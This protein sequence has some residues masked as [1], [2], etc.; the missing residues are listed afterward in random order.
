M[1]TKKGM[2]DRKV[3]FKTKPFNGP[4]REM[5]RKELEKVIK[6][7]DSDKRSFEDVV[8]MDK[9]EEIAS[10]IMKVC[11][12]EYGHTYINPD[13]MK[14]AV[15]LGDSNPFG[16]EELEDWVKWEII[17]GYKDAELID[18]EVDAEW[19]PGHSE[20][21]WKKFDGKKFK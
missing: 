13:E 11:M 20:D 9:L 5:V 2:T 7:D 19:V 1:D 21:G 16:L 8:D 15:V 6:E 17:D 12:G 10:G 4:I 3:S 18:V 14:I